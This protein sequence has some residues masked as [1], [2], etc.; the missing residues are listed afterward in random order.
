MSAQLEAN[1]EMVRFSK[2]L[3]ERLDYVREKVHEFAE[4]EAEYRKAKA[5]AWLEAPRRHEDGEKVTAN[6]R[7]AMVNA[8]TADERQ[9]RDIAEGLKQAGYEAVRSARQQLSAWQSRVAADRAE[10]EFVRTGPR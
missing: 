1:R 10:A 8:A 4:A 2:A 5:V 6:E 3:D 9:R 7:E